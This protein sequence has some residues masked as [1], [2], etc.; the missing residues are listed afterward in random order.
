MNIFRQPN[1]Q[2]H[3]KNNNPNLFQYLAKKDEQPSDRDEDNYRAIHNQIQNE[4][5]MNTTADN[6]KMKISTEILRKNNNK[7]DLES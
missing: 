7:T 1:V 3:L 5:E 6:F 4:T 2:T